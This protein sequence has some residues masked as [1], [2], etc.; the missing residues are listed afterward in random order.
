[1]SLP[2]AEKI[3]G[4]RGLTLPQTDGVP[5]KSPPLIAMTSL[6]SASQVVT[7]QVQSLDSLRAH[8][9]PSDAMI[10]ASA[11]KVQPANQNPGSYVIND[12]VSGST[13]TI[14]GSVPAVTQSPFA[15]LYK[16]GSVYID[17]IAADY[18]STALTGYTMSQG[19]SMEM[20][21]NYVNFTNSTYTIGFMAPSAATYNFTLGVNGSAAPIVTWTGGTLVSSVTVSANTWNH[22]ACSWDGTTL[23]LYVNGALGN[24]TTSFTPPT[25]AQNF[26]VGRANSLTCT[27]YVTDVRIVTNPAVYT[28][29]TLTVP[30][31]PLSPA[32]AGTTNFMM[33]VGQNSPT[34]QS[35]ALTFDRGLK[36]F[37]NFG[38]QTFNIVT[39][40]FTAVWRGAF[41]GT[42][43]GYETIFQAGQANTNGSISLLRNGTASQVYVSVWPSNSATG[44]G[45]AFSTNISQSTTY[46]IAGRY[47]PAT[48]LLDIWVNGVFANAVTVTTS[49][50]VA[51][52]IVTAYA[53]WQIA[54]FG[55]SASMSSNTLAI[56]NRALS[57]VE[58]LNAYSALTTN[59]I[60]APIEIGDANGTPALSIAG[61]GRVNVTKLGQTSNVVQW[62][63]AAMT[64][65]VTSINGQN[66]VAS[67]SGDTSGNPVWTLFDKGAGYWYTGDGAAYSTSAPYYYIGSKTT[68]DVNG[69]VY[70]G[71]WA[72]IQLPTPITL[73]SYSISGLN[74][75]TNPSL[76]VILGSRD[77]VNWTAVNSQ[78]TLTLV[79]T[80]TYTYTVPT[81]S[82]TFNYFRMVALA[83]GV[84][85]YLQMTEWTLYGTA[86][87][88]QQLTVAQ[89]VTLSYGAQTASLTGL[90]GSA[91]VPQDFSSSGLNIPAYVVS[92]T[93]T[94]A[95]TVAFSSFGPF[96]GEGSVYFPNG[97]GPNYGTYIS[98]P[99]SAPVCFDWS[100]LDFTIE[101][102][103]YPTAFSQG[104][105]NAGGIFKRITWPVSTYQFE[106]T[107]SSSGVVQFYDGAS[108]AAISP[109]G[110]VTLN[111][112]NHI[113]ACVSG[114]TAYASLNGVVGSAAKGSFTYNSALGFVISSGIPSNGLW[115]GVNGYISNFR[116]VRGIG[117]YTA[118]FTPSTQPLTAIQG[119]TQAGLPYGTVLLLRNAPAPGRV[120]TSKFAGAN[121]GGVNG[122]PL[123]LAFPPAAMTGYS[124]LLNSGYGQ[125]TYVAS[126][127]T[128]Q[129]GPPWGAFDKTIGSGSSGEWQSSSTYLTSSGAY[130]GTVSTVDVNG[131]SY[132]GEWLQLQMPS[133]IVISNY[134][135]QNRSDVNTQMCS[136]WWIF[137]S[138]DGNSWSLVD[139]RTGITWSLSQTQTFAVSSG[140][141]FTYY[142]IVTSITTNNS[143]S[144]QPVSI[145]EWTLNGTI[146]GPNVTADGRLG[147]GVSNPVQALEV[148]GSAVVAGTLSAGNPL[149]FR[150]ALYNGAMAINQRGISTNWASPTAMGTS[151]GGLNY[152]LDR[153]NHIRSALQ[154]GGAL[155]QGTLATTDAPFSQGLQY[156]LRVGRASG[157]TNTGFM[158]VAQMLESRESY[159][160]AGQAVT[161]SF[162]YRTGS[163]FSG[164]GIV[165]S[166]L[167]GTGTD[168]NGVVSNFTNQGTLTSPTYSASN[169]WQR[170]SFTSFIPPTSSQVGMTISYTPS[171]TAGGFD[172]FDVTGVQLEKGTLA[173]PFE[174]R[175]YAV[176]LQLCQRY[177]YQETMPS[178]SNYNIVCPM[179]IITGTTAMGVLKYPVTMR[180]NAVTFT[181][182]GTFSLDWY[183]VNANSIGALGVMAGGQGSYNYAQL[184]ATSVGNGTVGSV[185]VGQVR[186]LVQN[187][188]GGYLA[189][190]AEL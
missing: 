173:T 74:T 145:S 131:T 62:P 76:W 104:G 181:S 19:I 179:T 116:V 169:A 112:W 118:N 4:E 71:D 96:A 56:Y 130:N 188:A 83:T 2:W 59:T 140:Q 133:S 50:L 132:L 100:T 172:Y 128:E 135:L 91:Y 21:V 126:A 81:P 178:V 125:G 171:G 99:S 142:R 98:F 160:F 150:N 107:L 11:T 29:S 97:T 5:E 183:T 143:G 156:Y 103:F 129:F 185:T 184:Y 46:V 106:L 84:A 105:A 35:G 121:S 146:E 148:A 111:A 153:M 77:G 170:V 101:L 57:N 41:T 187:T 139:S 18:I 136:K 152:S 134:A 154:S 138:R 66:Y 6:V 127:S 102:W 164:S 34:I 25:L 61:D 93:A 30:S 39:Q 8:S 166:L 141:A 58:I 14:N 165:G 117:L 113:S 110:T 55:V 12:Q 42:P 108:G 175:P 159:K 86:D 95:N 70:K 151:A 162:F 94:V 144:T 124:T 17:G 67:A 163:G 51:D 137:G 32:A 36:Q 47:S 78:G 27:A 43:G 174:V 189:I 44:V 7:G 33:R 10:F 155:A 157:D 161:F 89:P 37:M 48:Q 176:E 186:F 123:T 15:D 52:R 13:P 60:N 90:A 88:A 147:L 79:N 65:Y 40:G 16:E 64:G 80:T 182:S 68:S 72:Q 168:Q 149:M 45:S 82:Q 109:S 26:L 24:S 9:L 114:S 75:S 177:Y 190:S 53:G 54:Q 3:F 115:S 167:Y 87:T 119:T 28:G 92:N 38:P 73:S 31:A 20:F 63:P 69:S 23:R 1:M 85:G 158:E 120:L 49:Q 122:A 180:S 22:L